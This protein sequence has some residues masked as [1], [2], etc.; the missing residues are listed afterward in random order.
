ME[1]K[2]NTKKVVITVAVL[3]VLVAAAVGC[4]LAFA[5]Q[6]ISGSK[7][8]QVQVVPAEG[9]IKEYTIHT[10]AEFLRGALEQEKL[11]SGAESEYGLYVTT[12]AGVTA[13]EGAQ[14]WWSFTKDGEIL[15]TGVDTTPV[16]DGEHYE[17][18]LMTGW[19]S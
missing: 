7:T 8:L 12:V 13:D 5:P 9:E 2:K 11:I 10:D 19:D 1:S 17:I 6:G 3:L 14:Q 18:T 4:W 16:A 15:N